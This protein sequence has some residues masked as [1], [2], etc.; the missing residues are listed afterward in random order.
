[1]G[2]KGREIVGSSID[3][4]VG[5]LKVAYCNE[6]TAFHCYWY[7]SLYMQGIGSLTIAGKFKDSAMEEL[8]HAG[9]IAERLN[10]LA[11]IAKF[12]GRLG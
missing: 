1:M 7:T 11:A 3:E 10:Q 8:E 2:K 12:A 5:G 9:M 6:L 4:I